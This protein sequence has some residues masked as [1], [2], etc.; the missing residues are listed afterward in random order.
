MLRNLFLTNTK[1]LAYYRTQIFKTA[2]T[3]QPLSFILSQLNQVHILNPISLR[4]ILI[5][6]SHLYL[7]L[8]R[9]L[10]YSRSVTKIFHA[11]LITLC[12][13]HSPLT[14][15]FDLFTLIIFLG[16]DFRR[17]LG[18]FLFTTASRTALGPLQPP[19]Q[20]V[21]EALSLGVKQPGR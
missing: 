17:G 7:G 15:C 20:W 5:L 16:F 6:S 8:P 12:V 4:S 9:D 19:I 10:F 2:L 11:F 3:R 14:P 13:L 1:S 21:S 18:I